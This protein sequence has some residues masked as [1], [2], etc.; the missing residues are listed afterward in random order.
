MES[1]NH[2]EILLV[3]DNPADIRWTQEAFKDGHLTNRLHVVSDAAAALDFLGNRGDHVDA[4]T[5]GLILLDLHL[6]AMDGRELLRR[7]REDPLHGDVPVIV[8]SGSLPEES[9][10]QAPHLRKPVDF[11][12]LI[13]TITAFDTLAL[14]IVGAPPA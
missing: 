14:Q 9:G 4:P 3:D 5:P 8:L 2:I 12:E 7:I 13:R 1:A 11:E 10:I 6:P